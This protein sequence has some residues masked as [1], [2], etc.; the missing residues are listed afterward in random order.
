[1]ARPGIIDREQ[2][3]SAAKARLG[4]ASAGLADEVPIY[5]GVSFREATTAFAD[6]LSITISDPDHSASE[7]R[8]VDIS[9]SYLGRLPVISYTER[10]DSIRV[11][12]AR[13]ATRNER[14]QYEEAD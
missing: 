13:P 4:F 6:P 10:G 5:N 3:D 14:K 2:T 1:V 8:F 11:I 7:L 12:S 9:T